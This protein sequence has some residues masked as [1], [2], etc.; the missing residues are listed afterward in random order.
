MDS[1]NIV[2]LF[3]EVLRSNDVIPEDNFFDLG[4]NSFQALSVVAEIEKRWGVTLPLLDFIR[5]PTADGIADL[6]RSAREG[7]QP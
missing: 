1:L 2:A 5:T 4:G 3:S 6:I 7:S